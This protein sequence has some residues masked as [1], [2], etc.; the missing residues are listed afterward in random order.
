MKNPRTTNEDVLNLVDNLTDFASPQEYI[1]VIDKLFY[2]MIGNSISKNSN[3]DLT[4]NDIENL[5]NLRNVLAELET[6]TKK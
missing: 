4:T 3:I 1:Q 5:K 6:V 2:E